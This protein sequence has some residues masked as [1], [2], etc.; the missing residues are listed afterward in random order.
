MSHREDTALSLLGGLEFDDTRLYDL[1]DILIRDFYTLDR[2]INPPSV[3][4]FGTSG[5]Q[6]ATSSDV[7]NFSGEIFPNNLRLTWDAISG[8]S[9]YD[10]RYKI[11]V[12]TD[13]DWDISNSIL[14]TS[15]LSA[16]INPIGIPLTIGDHSFL[17]KAVNSIG[18]ASTEAS[19]VVVT[20]IQIPAPILTSTVIDNNVLLSWTTPV[21]QFNIAY[22]NIYKDSELS[23]TM[24]GTFE[25]IFETIAGDYEYSVEAVD[26]VGNV[27]V[28]ANILVSV[29]QP[30]DY[31]L[32]D[33]YTSDLSGTKVNVIGTDSLLCCV[34]TC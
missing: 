19:V 17:I 34:L 12:A 16:D 32:Q 3:R 15:S 26:I 18:I 21:S 4:S 33:D 27:G 31:E 22:Y 9:Y 24:N 1:L 2:Q 7:L 20:V 8:T 10:I 28:L 25:A 6:L 23:G 11:G 30:P 14:R 29:N 5:V 13:S